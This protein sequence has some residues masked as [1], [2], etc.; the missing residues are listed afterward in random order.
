MRC[1]KVL[2][3]NSLKKKKSEKKNV[4]YHY[5]NNFVTYY[6]SVLSF[7]E[8]ITTLTVNFLNR[9]I[10]LLPSLTLKSMLSCTVKIIFF[11]KV[12]ALTA[13]E[14]IP[15][16]DL[17]LTISTQVL[18]EFADL[19]VHVKVFFFECM[20]YFNFNKSQSHELALY[21]SK[22]DD[23]LIKIKRVEEIV[24]SSSV[25]PNTSSFFQY[26]QAITSIMSFLAVL[27]GGFLTTPITRGEFESISMSIES[28]RQAVHSLCIFVSV[29]QRAQNS[30]ARRSTTFSTDPNSQN[31]NNNSND[32]LSQ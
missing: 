11:S 17:L 6:A 1:Q 29:A 20:N 5:F 27:K 22:M 3:K 2:I 24:A 7:I 31:F 30:E 28:I 15:Y 32:L 16:P 19:V 10:L 4:F 23:M 21:Q 18:T 9:I 13:S 14:T 12:I 25:K 8:Q 26:A